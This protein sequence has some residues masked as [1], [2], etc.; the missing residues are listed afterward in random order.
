VPTQ[1]A[2]V[3]RSIFTP[4]RARICVETGRDLA[5]RKDAFDHRRSDRPGIAASAQL[6]RRVDTG[7]RGGMARP[8]HDARHRGRLTIDDP[9][10]MATLGGGSCGTASRM[11]A[12][13]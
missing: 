2:S 9:E 13:V 3:E 5:F 8:A 1:L 10:L 12:I 6:R 7:D 11:K 4:D